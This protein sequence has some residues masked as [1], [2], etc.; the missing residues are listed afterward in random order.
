MSDK[1]IGYRISVIGRHEVPIG[2][3]AGYWLW[4]MGRRGEE[5][6]GALEDC[7]TTAKGRTDGG[8]T[9]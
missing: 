6:G 2:R 4:A 3:P 9:G 1:V 7:R 5:M 8:S